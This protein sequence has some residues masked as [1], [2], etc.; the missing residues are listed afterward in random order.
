VKRDTH[1]RASARPTLNVR[2]ER[3][4]AARSAS[5]VA[6]VTLVGLALVAGGCGGRTSPPVA[7]IATTT[8][9]TTSPT[10][11]KDPIAQ[12]VRYAAC[13]R[14]HGLPGFPDPQQISQGSHQ[15]IRIQVPNSPQTQTAERACN[16]FLP[17]GFNSNPAQNAQQGAH[18][19]AFARCM[20]AHGVPSFPDPTSGGS[21]P[22]SITRIDRGS[23]TVRSAANTCLPLAGGAIS[24]GTGQGNSH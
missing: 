10:Q 11:S 14:S 21:F 8:P 4:L 5:I 20:R 16:R 2:Q 23:P 17:S 6:G 7:R 13:M 3:G 19:L 1:P 18:L 24:F 12:A 15:A 22:T 9:G